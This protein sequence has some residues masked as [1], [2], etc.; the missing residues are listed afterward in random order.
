MHF[1]KMEVNSAAYSTCKPR[2]PALPGAPED[3]GVRCLSN[4]ALGLLGHR[5]IAPLIDLSASET[6][7]GDIPA[8]ALSGS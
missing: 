3:V 5:E 7:L 4:E 8:L 2:G 1:F 6:G